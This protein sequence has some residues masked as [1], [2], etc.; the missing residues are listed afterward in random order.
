M[1]WV[2]AMVV[3]T[4]SIGAMC[5]TPVGLSDLLTSNALRKFVLLAGVE[6]IE[7]CGIVFLVLLRAQW[8]IET[9]QCLVR[10]L[11]ISLA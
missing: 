3:I 10:T 2:V 11:P 4:S 1:T 5:V 9:P 6:L 7:V 8:E